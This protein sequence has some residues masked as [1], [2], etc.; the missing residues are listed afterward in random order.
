MA[1]CEASRNVVIVASYKLIKRNFVPE[2]C[3]WEC[4]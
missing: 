2:E 1:N 3:G 4:G